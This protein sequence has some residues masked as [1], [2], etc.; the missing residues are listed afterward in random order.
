MFKKNKLMPLFIDSSDSLDY[1]EPKQ[2]KGKHNWLWLIYIDLIL[3]AL[4]YLLALAGLG[5]IS[6]QAA[7]IFHNYLLFIL[8]PWP[9]FQSWTGILCPVIHLAFLVW[10]LKSKNKLTAIIAP[11]A[12]LLLV[13]LFTISIDGSP[14]NYFL[15][16]F[17]DFGL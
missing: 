3:P 13:G 15:I 1:Y 2:A 9:D 6:M 11:L 7:R 16:R 4:I 10:A 14:L 8:F 17:L 12:W 5:S